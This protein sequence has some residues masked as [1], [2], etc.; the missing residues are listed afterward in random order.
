MGMRTFRPQ[1]GE[2]TSSSCVPS[3]EKNKI[4][5]VP[6][7]VF[8]LGRGMTIK[9]EQE[10]QCTLYVQWYTHPLSDRYIPTLALLSF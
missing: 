7:A 1:Q 9:R 6:S 2:K 3:H 5:A 8:L 4:D 10:K